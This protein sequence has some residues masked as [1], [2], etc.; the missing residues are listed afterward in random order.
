MHVLQRDRQKTQGLLQRDRQ[1]IQELMQ[2]RIS[3]LGQV[4]LNSV[5]V[6]DTFTT[7]LEWIGVGPNPAIVVGHLQES[8]MCCSCSTGYSKR[9]GTK[10]VC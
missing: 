3:R 4:L 6:E 10:E 1:R 7:G 8:R 9:M 5:F 2:R